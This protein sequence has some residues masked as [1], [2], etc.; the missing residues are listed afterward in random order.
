MI[1]REMDTVEVLR[2]HKKIQELDNYLFAIRQNLDYHFFING[3]S[4]VQHEFK[5]DALVWSC[6]FHEKVP[7]YSEEVYKMSS[8]LL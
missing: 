6:I 2:K 4:S 5:L 1:E 8:Y 7:R 3:I